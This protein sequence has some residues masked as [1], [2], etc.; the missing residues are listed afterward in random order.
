MHSNTNMFY[1][2]YRCDSWQ[3]YTSKLK[4]SKDVAF[5]PFF[6]A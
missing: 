3:N 4:S 2:D 1:T 6:K 5:Y